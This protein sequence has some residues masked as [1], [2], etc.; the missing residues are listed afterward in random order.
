MNTIKHI[1]KLCTLVMLFSNSYVAYTQT[2]MDTI[3]GA[4]YK[5]LV[6]KNITVECSNIPTQTDPVLI[7]NCP[8][9]KTAALFDEFTA[10]E[11]CSQNYTIYRMWTVYTPC[12]QS[13]E[14]EQEIYVVDSKAPT[15]DNLPADITVQCGAVPAAS[16]V[17]WKD[18]C[19][20]TPV[21][22]MKEVTLPIDAFSSKIV[23][24]W[25][26]KDPCGN[27][28][29]QSQ[30]I[31]IT[32]SGK[33]Y[34]T[35]AMKDLT[36]TCVAIPIAIPP[37]ALDDCDK[38]PTVSL[39]ETKI[40]GTC[41]D[42]YT[43]RRT[44]TAKD[45]TGNTAELVQNVIVQDKIAPNFTVPANVSVECNAIPRAALA[46]EL[47]VTDNCTKLTKVSMS[48]TKKSGTCMYK[49]TLSRTFTVA[50]GCN[51]KTTKTQVVTVQD[52]KAP[53]MTNTPLNTTVTCNATPAVFSPTMK[54]NCTKSVKVTYSES[55]A[56]GLCANNY[57]LK[58]TW[59]MSDECANKSTK[60]Q[61]ILVADNVAPA[62]VQVPQ[63]T[64]IAVSEGKMM[65]TK[66]NATDNCDK[67]VSI[68]FS[69]KLISTTP[70]AGNNQCTKFLQRTWL[71]T[72]KCKNT[73]TVNQDIY[74][75]DD[76]PPVILNVPTDLTLTCGTPIP[77][78]PTNIVAIDTMGLFK[79]NLQVTFYEKTT[80]GGC[81]G[82]SKIERFWTALDACNNAKTL[83]QKITFAVGNG[84]MGLAVDFGGNKVAND[85]PVMEKAE[86]ETP[87]Q[88]QSFKTFKTLD[89]QSITSV[90]VYT[91]DG[92]QVFVTDSFGRAVIQLNQHAAGMYLM[93][94]S[95]GKTTQ[96]K[97]F[98]KQ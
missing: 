81:S 28:A 49:Y 88:T 69:E 68:S 20:N 84:A 61:T 85:N 7:T 1:A 96:V 91:I 58:R 16:A 62:F 94:I 13:F 54:D 93:K 55:V 70:T 41:I 27:I 63:N 75:K 57:T 56:A 92:R 35:N 4:G 31:T 30:N 9:G 37:T 39:V 5:L 45:V 18:N 74:V 53:E 26:A 65:S 22:T 2:A 87:T 77:P 17:V 71:A 95:D 43:L 29:T 47:K 34:F 8:N 46:S 32:D 48:E 42:N 14:V 23:R 90:E 19:S 51:N 66:A 78:A 24:T 76:V 10:E 11:S 64:T 60:T 38:A 50:D 21:V 44:W 25:T 36:V 67:N 59:T 82:F 72:D 83:S 3:T 52:I 89:N 33:P 12:Q 73:S 79:D 15:V 86:I 80:P 98:M 6:P 40:T 97:K